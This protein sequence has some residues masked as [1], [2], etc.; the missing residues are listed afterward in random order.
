MTRG[1]QREVVEIAVM[2]PRQGNRLDQLQWLLY[3][4]LQL[5]GEQKH[6]C[7]GDSKRLFHVPS[8]THSPPIFL[9]A[10]APAPCFWGWVVAPSPGIYNNIQSLCIKTV[11]E[12]H[13]QSTT[14]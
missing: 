13:E 2:E 5:E 6:K 1:V 10:C 9:A 3:L 14:R 4:G 12:P 7:E 8:L 11:G